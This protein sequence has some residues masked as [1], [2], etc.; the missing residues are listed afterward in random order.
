MNWERL[1]VFAAVAEQSSVTAAAEALHLTRPAVSQHLRKLE[2]ETGCRLVE[3]AGRGIRLT[4]AGQVLAEAARSVTAAVS[5]AEHD[6]ADIHQQIIGSLRIGAV[7]SALRLFVLDALRALTAEHPRLRPTVRDGEGVD[8]IPAL[9]LGKLDAVV[10]ESW[11]GWPARMPAG[12]EL[13][14]LLTEDVQLAVAADH[15]LAE[16]ESVRVDELAGL[17]WA[18]CAPGSEPHEAL[19]QT[20]R[21]RAVDVEV[22][23]CVTDYATMLSIVAAGLAVAL[24]PGIAQRLDEPGVRYLDCEPRIRR[25]VAVATLEGRSTPAARAFVSELSRT[26]NI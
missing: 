15:P 8:L 16:R 6:L 22:D 21:S 25:T 12:V 13:T 1:R 9:R 26:A 2:R 23:H 24:V 3:P 17:R 11:T 5:A 18:S 4:N 7:A 19:V 20:L 14:E 10:F